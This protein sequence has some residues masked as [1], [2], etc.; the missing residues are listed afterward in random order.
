LKKEAI[1][2]TRTLLDAYD[3][4][5]I[6]AQAQL[7]ASAANGDKRDEGDDQI[8]G[9]CPELGHWSLRSP[10]RRWSSAPRIEYELAPNRP[11]FSNFSRNLQDFFSTYMPH[12]PMG[13]VA[14]LRV[15]YPDALFMLF[16]LITS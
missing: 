15:R 1:A 14:A 5:A 6:A 3:K 2:R 4:A 11:I 8:G 7:D 12:A 16:N 10:D 13:D 9:G